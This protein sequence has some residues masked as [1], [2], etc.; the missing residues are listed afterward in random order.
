MKLIDLSHS[1]EDGMQ[2]YPGDP[3]PTIEKALVHESDYCHVDRLN[4]GSH[5]GTH[6]DAPF[7]FLKEGRTIESYPP[8]LFFGKG[9]L[10]KVDT[11]KDEEAIVLDHIKSYLEQLEYCDFAVF[12][13][14]FDQYWGT[15]AYLKHPYISPEVATVL[16]E[17]GIKIVATDGLNVDPT[18]KEVFP[19][20]EILL[21]NDV[22]IV[23]NLCNLEAIKETVSYYSFLPLKIKEGDGSP[24][25]AIA[26]EETVL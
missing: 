5:T 22:L 13:T 3:A 18:L 4:L 17:K 15:E 20:H 24:I 14:G 11:L 23:E 16:V 19:T 12:K 9:C 2:I 1:I 21:G 10:I 6:I 26:I 7:H 8:D 25:R